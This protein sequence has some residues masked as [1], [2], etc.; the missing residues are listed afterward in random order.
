MTPTLSLLLLLAALVSRPISAESMDRDV[1]PTQLAD[2]QMIVLVFDLPPVAAAQTV[3]RKPSDTTVKL[4]FRCV[5]KGLVKLEQGKF[6][7]IVL[8]HSLRR[9]TIQVPSAFEVQAAAAVEDAVAQCYASLTNSSLELSHRRVESQRDKLSHGG[10]DLRRSM[11]ESQIISNGL[12]LNFSTAY[13][14]LNATEKRMRALVDRY[15][16]LVKLFV[17]GKSVLGVDILAIRVGRWSVDSTPDTGKQAFVFVG[18]HHAR[19]WI[20]TEIVSAMPELI[21]SLVGKSSRMTQLINSTYLWFMPVQNPDGYKYTW[22]SGTD[23]AG[24]E[25][26]MW[27]KNRKIFSDTNPQAVGV[28]LNRNYPY[29]WGTTD[30]ASS[31][32]VTSETYGGP[33]P[34][35]EIEVTYVMDFLRNTSLIPKNSLAGF[36]SYHSYGNYLLRPFGY[37]TSVRSPVDAFLGSL[38]AEMVRLMSLV[39][40]GKAYDNVNAAEMYPVNGDCVDWVHA[41]F[42]YLP[43]Y[44]V[45]SRP[46]DFG[47]CGFDLPTNQIPQTVSENLIAA[48]L[49]VDYLVQHPGPA[50]GRGI[51]RT[52]N[53]N[54]T[55]ADADGDGV[56]DY[57]Q[58][59]LSCGC[60]SYSLWCMAT[61]D[62]VVQGDVQRIGATET[63]EGLAR[64]LLNSSKVYGVTVDL[65]SD[66][67]RR[68]R[69]G[70]LRLTSTPSSVEMQR[71][72]FSSVQ[73]G[74]QRQD[75]ANLTR[76]VPGDH[77]T[78]GI[79]NGTRLHWWI[80]ESPWVSDFPSE[81]FGGNLDHSPLVPTLTSIS[82]PNQN[83]NSTTSSP[84]SAV[85]PASNSNSAMDV[86]KP[87]AIIVVAGVV[88]GIIAFCVYRY[89]GRNAEERRGKRGSK[90]GESLESQTHVEG[91]EL[92]GRRVKIGTGIQSRGTRLPT[93]DGDHP[94]HASGKETGDGFDDSD[95]EANDPLPAAH[96]RSETPISIGSGVTFLP[97]DSLDAE[98]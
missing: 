59:D 49:M 12:A 81:A 55:A 13:S 58:D 82:G 23:S 24:L 75:A 5:E 18:T 90:S 89:C 66:E 71:L 39:P 51:E 26:R 94:T 4:A 73:T 97:R 32:D 76:L 42:D 27:R 85:V 86:L 2:H 60:W 36:I 56:F 7:V 38:G 3:S 48:L 22:E 10:I 50:P 78:V 37:D 93:V 95:G 44:T 33:S 88:L 9:I 31:A 83:F 53:K 46:D 87:L 11:E 72:N 40:N 29:E 63:L 65:H 1:D 61:N 25:K 21:L 74:N 70:V 69:C 19:E 16:D 14:D 84:I 47:C 28:D 67:S 54:Y 20:S 43:S 96:R 8:R 17:V 52:W 57:F 62:A 34:A 15:P 91:T 77:G 79:P 68:T 98:G 41:T 64:T 6:P 80:V 92:H 45:E 35:S 30:D